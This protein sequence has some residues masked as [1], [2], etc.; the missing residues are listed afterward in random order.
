MSTDDGHATQLKE[1]V[2]STDDG[3]YAD[4]DMNLE[5]I[6]PSTFS[7]QRGDSD[8]LFRKQSHGG[9]CTYFTK[10]FSWNYSKILLANYCLGNHV[11]VEPGVILK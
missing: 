5:D 3:E 9:Q 6:K 10:R 7:K 8:V 11:F 2:S 4:R 1:E